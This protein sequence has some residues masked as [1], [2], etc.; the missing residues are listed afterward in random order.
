M[1]MTQ[2]QHI[3][4]EQAIVSGSAIQ[5]S[6]IEIEQ[7]AAFT[8]NAHDRLRDEFFTIRGCAPNFAVYEAHEYETALAE[9]TDII[10]VAGCAKLPSLADIERVLSASSWA[11][12]VVAGKV[13]TADVPEAF[14][15]E[16][17]ARIRAYL[18][19]RNDQV[20]DTSSA[21]P[22]RLE[23]WNTVTETVRR[24]IRDMEALAA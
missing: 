20:A 21:E 12:T 18:A 8:Y 15:T 11:D 10:E 23:R 6:V 17:L 1:D 4:P 2:A 24:V 14:R 3:V 19:W 13:S 5:G 7:V 16:V 9:G 22:A